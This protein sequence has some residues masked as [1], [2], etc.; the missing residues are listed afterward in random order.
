MKNRKKII[1]FVIMLILDWAFYYYFISADTLNF[2]FNN[3]YQT[4]DFT[5]TSKVDTSSSEDY[6]YLVKGSTLA[7]F[8]GDL[9]YDGNISFFDPFQGKFYAFAHEL[10]LPDSPVGNEV[11]FSYPVAHVDNTAQCIGSFDFNQFVPKSTGFGVITSNS[12]NGVAGDLIDF[13]PNDLRHY[14]IEVG[15]RVKY[16][17]AQ[18]FITTE[19]GDNELVDILIL[20]NQKNETYVFKVLEKEFLEDYGGI[21]YGMSGSPIVQDGKLVGALVGTSPDYYDIGFMRSVEDIRE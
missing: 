2:T 12:A 15:E 19:Y 7:L 5:E 21:L 11:Y 8:E 9:R 17:F 14:A 10:V 13:V 20:F 3:E 4:I 18:I 6:V 16:G 1:Y